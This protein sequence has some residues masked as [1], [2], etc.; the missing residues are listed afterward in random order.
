MKNM[1]DWFGMLLQGLAVIIS[2]IAGAVILVMAS[3]W[4]K[5]QDME[6]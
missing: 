2:L 5:I 4:E 1:L 3:L 6:I